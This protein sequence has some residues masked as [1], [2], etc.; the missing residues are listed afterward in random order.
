VSATAATQPSASRQVLGASG[1]ARRG[2]RPRA[3]TLGLYALLTA[4]SLIVAFPLLLAASYSF[5]SEGEI[6]SYP[7]RLVPSTFQ[8]DNYQ[9]VLSTVPLVRYLFNSFLASS[10]VVI[11]QLVTASL[12]AFAFSFLVFP[13]RNWLF[14]L[15]LATMMIPWE[16][17]I[18]PNYMTVR[19]LGWLDTYQGLSVPFMAQAF[20]TFL[21][22]QS[23]LQ[24]PRDLFD[25]AVVD[26][27]GKLRFLWAVVL[28]LSRPALA[29]LAVY[30]FL[31]T[32]NLY[33]WPLLVTND[34]QMRTTQVGIAQLRFEETLRWGYLM[35]GVTMI[36]L[37]TLLLL[38]LGQRHL[39]RGLTAGAVKG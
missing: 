15:F 19:A 7:P 12:A 36:V 2:V 32:W 28:P 4:A 11:G 5:M 25:A 17:T 16:A 30:A 13:G 38:V 1:V 31:W 27:A 3:R 34:P 6:A 35:A 8:L 39:V 23:F 14:G 24:L 18:I 20:G 33:F 29:T 21:L 9:R 37:P 10:L 22:R 26:G